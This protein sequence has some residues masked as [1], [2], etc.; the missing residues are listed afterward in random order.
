MH[1]GVETSGGEPW[2]GADGG[3]EVGDEGELAARDKGAVDG[4]GEGVLLM[5]E[6]VSERATTRDDIAPA[7]LVGRS[8]SLSIV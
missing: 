8:A 5:F 3:H 2:D 1:D 4:F 7:V 6:D